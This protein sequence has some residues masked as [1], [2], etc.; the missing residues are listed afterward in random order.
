[1]SFIATVVQDA[2]VL[3]MRRVLALTVLALGGRRLLQRRFDWS[4]RVVLI[5]G[6]SR[7]LGLLL[8]RR[9][10]KKG[11]RLVIG[12]RSEEELRR[13]RDHLAAEGIEAEIVVA[14][15]ADREQAS[16]L[17]GEAVGRYGRLDALINA[18]S[19]ISVA[20]LDALSLQDLHDAVN[21][22]FWG[23]VHTCWAALPHLRK[24]PN[25]RIVNITSIGGA[26]AV[27]HLLPYTCGKFA[28][29][30]FSEGLQAELARSS[31]R[32]TT[33]LPWL[34][35][36]GSAQHALV[37]GDKSAEATLFTLA[38]SLPLLTLSAERAAASSPDEAREHETRLSQSFLTR[39]G[40]RAAARYNENPV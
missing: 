8:A 29:T 30:G 10:G 24:A 6:G 39:L 40:R 21:V 32:V 7:G 2:E 15:V 13:A 27:P 25:A 34:M 35:R 11:A 23:T 14:D 3:R 20:P 22:N 4:G 33:V 5:A 9:L 1:M 36:T 38:G 19:I 18:A 17:I 37:K 28:A 12:A 31:V 26:I 16:A